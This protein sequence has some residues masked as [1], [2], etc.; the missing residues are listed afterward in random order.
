MTALEKKWKATQDKDPNR[1]PDMDDPMGQ[2]WDQ[3]SRDKILVDDKVALM[4]QSAFDALHDYSHS[5]PT[6]VY[7]GKMWRAQYGTGPN[8]KWFLCW[9]GH[10]SKGHSSK[11]E[12]FCSN[13]YREI[14]IIC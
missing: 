13:N 10:S 9:F 5:Q 11:G 4:E 12:K 7:P 1:I 3:P 6:G 8:K 2:H 14:V